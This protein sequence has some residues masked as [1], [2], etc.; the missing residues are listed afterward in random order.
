MVMSLLA[1]DRIDVNKGEPLHRA[2]EMRHPDV[3]KELLKS[4]LDVNAVKKYKGLGFHTIQAP[5]IYSSV[6]CT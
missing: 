1:C 6:H 5:M 4:K 3:V 2:A